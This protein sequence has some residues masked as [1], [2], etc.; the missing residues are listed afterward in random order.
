[1]SL[2]P[3][4][5]TY[6]ALEEIDFETQLEVCL[7]KVRYDRSKSNQEEVEDKE[8][9]MTVEEKEK[10]EEVKAQSRQVYDA[11]CQF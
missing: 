9:E 2:P 10:M 7:A 5:A 11:H 3:K 4:F 8:L 1:M 6:K